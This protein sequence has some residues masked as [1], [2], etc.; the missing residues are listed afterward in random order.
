MWLTEPF[1]LVSS[2][3]CETPAVKISMAKS[4]HLCIIMTQSTVGAII[5]WVAFVFLIFIGLESSLRFSERIK[6]EKRR[7]F[8]KFLTRPRLHYSHIIFV[9]W[10]LFAVLVLSSQAFSVEWIM[11]V[12]ISYVL[13]LNAIVR[14]FTIKGAK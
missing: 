2:T 5:F 8:C 9:I 10:I 11:L 1:F 4:F 3:C 6:T 13:I 12:V 14:R 7:S